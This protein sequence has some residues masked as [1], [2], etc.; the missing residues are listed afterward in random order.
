[1]NKLIRISIL[2]FL[3]IF[4]MSIPAFAQN[5]GEISANTNKST[6]QPG[7]K[8][9]ISGFVN[10]EVN[11]NPVTII[12]RNPIGNIYAVGQEKLINNAFNHDFVLNDD[13]QGGTYTINI[14]QG[15]QTTQIQFLVNAG[16]TITIPVLDNAIKVRT[17]GTNPIKY[18]DV[19]VSTTDFTIRVTMDTSG[20]SSNSLDQQYQ[21]PK[22]VI[23]APGSQLVVKV[24]GTPVTCTQSETNVTRIL[25]CSIQSNSKELELIGTVVIPEFGT[26]AEI[27]IAISITMTIVLSKSSRSTF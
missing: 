16:Q 6:Y 23:D 13:S 8:V 17:N 2:S 14:K 20:M 1:M 12:V 26:L 7:D 15:I 3:M 24:D 4:S 25:D 18:T 5:A 22:K 21:I 27:V 10:H 9:I 11:N 19:S